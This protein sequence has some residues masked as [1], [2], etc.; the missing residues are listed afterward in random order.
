V[1]SQVVRDNSL[2]FYPE[3]CFNTQNIAY[4]YGLDTYNTVCVR[5]L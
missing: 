1:F 2:K 3:A 5:L 4:C